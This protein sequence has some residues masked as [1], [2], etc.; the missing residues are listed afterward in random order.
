M[1]VRSLIHPAR[2]AHDPYIAVRAFQRSIDEAFGSG[3]VKAAPLSVR[4]DVKEDEK[5]YT[6]TADLPGLSDSDVEVTF[7][8][9]TLAI[10]GERKVAR[11]E[12]TDTWH[13]A[14][15]STGSFERKL[16]LSKD[17]MADKIEAKFDKGVLTVILPKEAQ[18]Q[19]S[20]RKIAI[21]TSQ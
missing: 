13:I 3:S 9:G 19:I 7:E 21:K 14:E 18:A 10:R 4:M 5:A 1:Y 11:D 17:V 15:R 20:A 8:D 16:S 12:K 6:V 2:F